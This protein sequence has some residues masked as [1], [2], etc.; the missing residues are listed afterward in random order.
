MAT[1]KKTKPNFHRKQERPNRISNCKQKK[2]KPIDRKQQ[3]P[4]VSKKDL[5]VSKN[6]YPFFIWVRA[7]GVVQQHSVFKARKRH[8]NFEHINF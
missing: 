8:K 6:D 4:T 5:P 7:K 1:E 2:T 3:R